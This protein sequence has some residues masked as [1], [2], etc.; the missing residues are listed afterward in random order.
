MKLFHLDVI[1][2]KN[3]KKHSQMIWHFNVS[4]ATELK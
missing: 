3:R 2:S 1:F 4:K